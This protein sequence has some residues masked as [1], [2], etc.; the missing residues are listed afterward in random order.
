LREKRAT[1]TA[2]IRLL[3][4]ARAALRAGDPAHA[5]VLLD[6]FDREHPRPVLADEATV[7]RVEALLLRGEAE[8]ANRIGEKLL[9]ERPNSVQAQRVRSLIAAGAR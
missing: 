4:Q 6:R 8:E 5:E 7:T 2:E 9:R 1:A 3:D